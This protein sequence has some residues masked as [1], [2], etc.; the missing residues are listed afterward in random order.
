MPSIVDRGGVRFGRLTA[1]ERIQRRRPNGRAVVYWRCECDC[2]NE[3]V[4]SASELREDRTQSC[5]CLVSE[6]HPRKHGASSKADK[7]PEYVIWRGM[8]DRCLNPNSTHWNRYGGRGIMICDRWQHDFEAFLLDM[9]ARPSPEL[10]I[11]RIDNNGNYE[12][13]NCRWAT[14]TEQARNRAP[15][16]RRMN[17]TTERRTP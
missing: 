1:I 9:G 17:G 16:R 4:V 12:P 14:R 6:R 5:G 8:K 2:G 7:M 3:T 11:D 15:R 10:T 13:D